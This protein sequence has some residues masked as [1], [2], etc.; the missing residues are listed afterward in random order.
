MDPEY[1]RLEMLAHEAFIRRAS[2]FDAPFMLKGSYVTR[3]YFEDPTDRFPADLDWVCLAP[4]H[5]EKA[6]N[7]LLSD[8]AVQV[9]ETNIDDGVKF[10]SFTKNAFWRMIDYAMDDDFPTVNTDLKCYVHGKEM[11]FSVDVSLNLDIEEPP[12]PLQYFPI[13]GES[14]IVPKTVPMSL[15]VSWK[16]HQ[17]LIRPRFKDLFDLIHLLWHS[18]FDK[19]QLELAMQALINECSVDQV[20]P[21][22]LKYFLNGELDRL[23]EGE[24]I[25]ATWE[26]WRHG[27]MV[28]HFDGYVD[29][30]Q[31]QFS[32]NTEKLPDQLEDFIAMFREALYANGLD[33]SLWERLP[34]PDKTERIP[35][36]YSKSS[37]PNQAIGS[38][39]SLFDYLLR[40]YGN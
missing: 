31:G 12:I 4:L 17:T 22:K 26:R 8:W 3:Q 13:E 32:T 40:F 30:D 35:F 29:Y 1:Q 11:E 27:R 36:A 2:T 33:S 14:F 19:H 7:V 39:Q 24:S 18:S 25:N 9:T 34:E 21:V 15:Q 38:W 10:V 5:D 16:I 28:P 37:P 23:F 20:D 6:A